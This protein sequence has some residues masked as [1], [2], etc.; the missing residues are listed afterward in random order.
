M[1]WSIVW[2]LG[3][4]QIFLWLYRTGYYAFH[5]FY[6]AK[7]TTERYGKNS[8]AVVTGATDGIGKG[9]AIE[10]AKRGFNIVLI[11]RTMSKLE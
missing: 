11:S 9:F 7:V 2:C 8:W 4:W 1:F 3:M 5:L 10:L 6:G